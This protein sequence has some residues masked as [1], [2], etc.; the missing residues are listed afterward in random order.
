MKKPA[1]TMPETIRTTLFSNLDERD[2]S[3]RMNEGERKLLPD[4]VNRRN[5][6]NEMQ[7]GVA[8]QQDLT[9]K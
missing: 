3:T 2:E 8:D 1:R 5:D 9:K 6:Q 4:S 7:N